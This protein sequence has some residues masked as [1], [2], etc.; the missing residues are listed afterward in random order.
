MARPCSYTR[1]SPPGGSDSWL[2]CVAVR[3]PAPMLSDPGVP[4]VSSFWSRGTQPLAE[5]F[6][7][8]T[9][10]EARNVFDAL[11]AELPGN[12]HSKRSAECDGKFAA[13]HPVGHE[14][15]RVHCIGHVDAVPP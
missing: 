14:R 10:G 12:T 13:I 11:V 9:N 15:L 4:R 5:R 3:S 8:I 6:E 1:N 7:T 2:S